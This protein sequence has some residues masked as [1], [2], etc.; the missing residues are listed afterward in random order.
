MRV[1]VL[2]SRI[3]IE[4]KLIIGDLARRGVPFD[5][6][7]VRAQAFDLH[8]GSWTSYDVILDRCLSQTQALAALHLLEQWGVPCVNRA[9]VVETCGDKLRT[10]LALERAGVPTPRWQVAF[11]PEAALT[12]IESIGYPVVLKPVVGSWGRL[13]ARVNDRDAAEALLEHKA[14]LG[15]PQH[16]IFY[17]Q[18]YIAKRGRDVRSFVVGEQ[19]ICAISR[20]AAHWIT[21]TARGGQASN[22]P[23]TPALDE[24]SRAAARAVG[25][26]VLAVDLFEPEPGEWLVNEVNHTMEFRNSVAPT[27]V[28]IP[29]HLVAYT[30]AVAEGMA[31]EAPEVAWSRGSNGWHG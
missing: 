22:C 12:A 2:V 25:G 27:G 13:L 18:Q 30:L 29:A 17:V 20:T 31:L 9:A 1:G 6:I 15:G 24:I 26:G 5:L 19:T 3:R 4:E 7:D 16:S 11:T 14:T 8:A 23:V 21:N 28:D 10:S